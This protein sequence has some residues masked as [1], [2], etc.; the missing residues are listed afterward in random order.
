M[1]EKAFDAQSAFLVPGARAEASSTE[2][3]SLEN[4][5]E[6]ESWCSP[7]KSSDSSRYKNCSVFQSN[8]P[9]HTDTGFEASK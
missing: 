3:E 2:L 4:M 9:L 6:C 8:P 5:N 7:I 1:S